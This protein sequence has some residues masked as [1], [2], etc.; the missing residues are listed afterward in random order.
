M[1]LGQGV[2]DPL[3]FI[4]AFH[5]RSVVQHPNGDLEFPSKSADK[6]RRTSERKDLIVVGVCVCSPTNT[7]D[8]MSAFIFSGNL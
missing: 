1:C 6:L 8:A 5:V 3:I 2:V 4:E 7:A